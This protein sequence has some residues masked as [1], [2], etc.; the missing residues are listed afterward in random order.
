MSMK[1]CFGWGG[2]TLAR[3]KKSR[4]NRAASFQWSPPWIASL[5]TRPR[6]LSI[7]AKLIPQAGLDI[8]FAFRACCA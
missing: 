4:M 7:L 8:V 2:L 6:L 5:L 3:K 1:G